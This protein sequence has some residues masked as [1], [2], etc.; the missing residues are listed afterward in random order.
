MS[1]IIDYIKWRGDLPFEVDPF[2]EIDSLILAELSYLPFEKIVDKEKEAETLNCIAKRFFSH[3]K[4]EM[5]LGAIIPEKDIKELFTLAM[6]SKRFKNI[7]VRGFESKLCVKEQIQFYGVYF[8][9]N[10]KQCCIAFRGTDDSL[11]GWKENF[12]MAINMPIPSQ[13]EATK[14]L[15][16]IGSRLRKEIYVCGHSK[17][18]NLASYA[19]IFANPKVKKKIVEVHSFDG[20]GFRDDFI[21]NINFDDVK[22]KIIK[23]LPRS[24]I[25][26]MIYN[27]VGKCVYLDSEGKGAYQHDGFKWKIIGNKFVTVKKLDKAAIEAH[28]LIKKWTNAM[29]NEEISDFVEASYKLITVNESATLSDISSDKF[30]FVMGLIKSDGKTKKIFLSAIKKLIKEK[31]F[32]KGEKSNIYNNESHD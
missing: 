25:V 9:L 29:T 20:P 23:F 28:H 11:V 3:S 6:N 22:D 5:H 19:A 30:K 17:G 4:E 26:G 7:K 12:N 21:E 24:S 10:K 2:N 1:N 13:N 27:P 32:K 18:G 16:L 15:N 8:E 14:F 31:Y